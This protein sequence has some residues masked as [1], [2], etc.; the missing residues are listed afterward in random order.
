MGAPDISSNRNQTLLAAGVCAAAG[1]ALFQCFGNAAR[2]YI[3]TSSLFWWWFSQWLDPR[4]E[5]EHG[6]L[7]LGFSA[8]LVWRNGWGGRGGEGDRRRQSGVRERNS[9]SGI[10]GS[11]S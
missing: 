5:T 7:I 11:R 4:A 1:L 2:G 6:W 10:R 3:D 9:E 8:W